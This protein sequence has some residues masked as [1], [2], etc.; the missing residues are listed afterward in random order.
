MLG[1]RIE[2]NLENKF[3]MS[4][5][6]CFDL[7]VLTLW[8]RPCRPR[9]CQRLPRATW[10]E[11]DWRLPLHLP[12]PVAVR[13]ETDRECRRRFSKEPPSPRRLRRPSR[14]LPDAPDSFAGH[15]HRFSIRAKSRDRLD[16]ILFPPLE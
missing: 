8:W 2:R 10:S 7:A 4:R 3:E 1:K 6:K 9:F 13:P 14:H 16:R 5:P 12:A 15:D 11:P